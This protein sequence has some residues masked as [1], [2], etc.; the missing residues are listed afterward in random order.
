MKTKI[1][2]EDIIIHEVPLE[3]MSFEEGKLRICVDDIT[4]K[5]V[6]LVFSPII[7]I[8]TILFDQ[9][10]SRELSLIRTCST[11]G[12]KYIVEV[13]DSKWIK[14]LKAYA[15]KYDDEIEDFCYYRHFYLILGDYAVDIIA[16]SLDVIV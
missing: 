14:K 7:C 2:R 12:G 6:T 16:Y 3:T 9:D 11:K 1:I 4:E 15:E 13:L 8:K 10:N 5:R